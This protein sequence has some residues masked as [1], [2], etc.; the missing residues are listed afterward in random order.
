MLEK[1]IEIHGIR[2]WTETISGDRLHKQRFTHGVPE[3]KPPQKALHGPL[4][5]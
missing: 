2:L 3:V 5:L 4:S 1:S